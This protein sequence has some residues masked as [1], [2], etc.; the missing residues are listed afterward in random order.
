MCGILGIF[1][2]TLSN[3]ELKKK[4]IQSSMRLRHRGPDWSGYIVENGTGI[5]HER[6][7]IID[8]ES[9]TQPLESPNGNIVV[10]A[11]GEIY[12]YR[13]RWRNVIFSHMN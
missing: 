10:A 9:G 2:S 7:A 3:V 6:L 1:G 8:P 4:L 11:N 5:A 13:V 12:N